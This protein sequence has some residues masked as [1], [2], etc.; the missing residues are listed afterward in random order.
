[1]AWPN[2]LP[3]APEN[4]RKGTFGPRLLCRVMLH[5]LSV[6]SLGPCKWWAL[7]HLLTWGQGLTSKTSSPETPGEK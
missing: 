1:M 6:S 4:D 5:P 3:G 7:S 2:R